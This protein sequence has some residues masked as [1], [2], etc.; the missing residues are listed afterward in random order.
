[1]PVRRHAVKLAEN[2]ERYERKYRINMRACAA[3]K[4]SLSPA[5]PSCN[6]A[7]GGNI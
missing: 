1:M 6:F 2:R 5:A 7:I 3:Y 4:S